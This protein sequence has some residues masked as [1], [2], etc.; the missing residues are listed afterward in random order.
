MNTSSWSICPSIRRAGC[1]SN[2]FRLFFLNHE[3]LTSTEYWD[4][5]SYQQEQPSLN[6]FIE[7]AQGIKSRFFTMDIAKTA[8]GDWVVIE[9]GDGQVSGLPIH[10]NIEQ[11]YRSIKNHMI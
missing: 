10:T 4:E 9:V 3:L 11:F 1:R 5:A 7:L 2:E 8:G 6:P